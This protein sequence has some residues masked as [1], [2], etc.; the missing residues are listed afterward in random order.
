MVDSSDSPS[1]LQSDASSTL[2]NGDARSSCAA[3]PHES[4]AITDAKRQTSEQTD[5]QAQEVGVVSSL[6][7]SRTYVK[8]THF[9]VYEMLEEVHPWSASIPGWQA[10]EGVKEFVEDWP[11]ILRFFKEC[12]AHGPEMI[13]VWVSFN[14]IMAVMPAISLYLSGQLMGVVS[15]VTLEDTQGQ[16]TTLMIQHEDPT[17]Y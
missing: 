8:T 15:H 10:W 12:Q 14:I 6:L 2:L 5:K 9:G 13:V 17:L 16:G 1:Q 11:F 4:K 3:D 7:K